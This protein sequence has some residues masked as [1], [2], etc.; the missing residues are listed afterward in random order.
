MRG[1]T[2]RPPTRSTGSARMRVPSRPSGKEQSRMATEQSEQMRAAC[3]DVIIAVRNNA[4]TIAR[5]VRS[6]LS[7]P[8]VNRVIVVDDQSTDETVSV[9]SALIGEF[10]MRLH[11]ER[12]ERNVGPAAARNRAL[13]LSDA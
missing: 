2:F 13:A 1:P 11:L 10:G 7:A 3:V 6:A 12:M 5:A 9:I 4:G 8:E